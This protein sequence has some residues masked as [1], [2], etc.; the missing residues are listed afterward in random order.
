MPDEPDPPR[1]IYQLGKAGF[2]PVNVPPETPGAAAP[3]QDVQAHLR[4]NLARANA[5]GLNKIDDRPPR[6][7]RR[8]RDYWMLFLL[9]NGVL[10]AAL[11]YFG[12]ETLGGAF[13]VS[14]MIFFSAALTWVMFGVMSKY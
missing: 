11:L 7:S 2:E 10:G 3:A 4:D 9:G 8:K 12:P 14:A 13:A 6:P 1:K 5:A